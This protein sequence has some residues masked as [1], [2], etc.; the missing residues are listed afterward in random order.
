MAMVRIS[1]TGATRMD[2]AAVLDGEGMMHLG[3]ESDSQK[4]QQGALR[5]TK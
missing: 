2:A 1:L 3:R 4:P 5:V